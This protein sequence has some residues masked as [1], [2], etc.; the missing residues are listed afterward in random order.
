MLMPMTVALLAITPLSPSMSD[1]RMILDQI[2]PSARVHV[3]EAGRIDRIYGTPMHS[4]A[5]PATAADAFVRD[6]AAIWAVR[7]DQLHPVGHPQL[8]GYQPETGNYKFTLLTYQ[9][10]VGDV[11]VYESTLRVLVRNLQRPTVVLASADLHPTGGWSTSRSLSSAEAVVLSLNAAAEQLGPDVRLVDTPQVVV[12]AGAGDVAHEPRLVV[13]ATAAVGTNGDAHYAKRR[14]VV[15]AITGEVLHEENRIVQCMAA[16]AAATAMGDVTGTVSARV[17]D[18]WSAWECD[19]TITEP[20]P[21][22]YVDVGGNIVTTDANGQFSADVSGDVTV[23]AELRGPWFN[24]NNI[25]GSDDLVSADAS[26]GDDV[27]LLF[28]KDETELIMAQAV[29][30]RDANLVRDFILSVNPT[31][32][33]I[34][35]QTDW[36]INVNLSDTCNAYYD[37]SSINFFQTGGGCNNTAFGHVVF[38]EYGHHLIAEA[39]SGQGEYG[40]GM[41]DCISLLMTGDPVMA[42]GFFIGNCVSGI[43]DADNSCQYSETGCSSCGSAIH[44]CGQLISGCVYDTW[45][46]LQSKSPLEAHAIISSLTIDSILLHTGTGINDA[47]AIDF[48]TLDDDDGNLENGSPNYNEIAQGFNMHDL[49]V[50]PIAWL[51]ITLPEGPPS[52]IQPDGM[53]SMPV[54]IDSL[55]GNY[56]S[57]TARLFAGQDGTTTPVDLED[58]GSGDFLA[59][60]P[61]AECGE[62]VDWFIWAKTVDNDNTFL[63]ATAPD[64]RIS[65][66]AAWS[67]PTIAFADDGATDPG[68]TVSGDATDGFWER[69]IP[70]GGNNRPNEDCGTGSPNCWITEN[71]AGGGGDVDGGSTILTSPMIDATGVDEV[72]YCWWYRNIG[73]GNNVEDDTWVVNVSDDNGAT[74]TLLQQ[75]DVTGP[76]VEGNW[77]TSTFDLTELS[78]FELNEQFRIQFVASD[79]NETSRVEA[80]VDNVRMVQIDCS[81]QPCPSDID[82][83]GDVGTNDILALL[84]AWGDCGSCPEDVTGDGIVGV[85]D[86][87]MLVGSFGPCP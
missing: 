24:T 13:D 62:N 36:P 15:D 49:N 78:G 26:D 85:D 87:L 68:W 40:E 3:T 56:Q 67:E 43:R 21:W 59:H 74:W 32:P 61:T 27:E 4:A 42:P 1:T 79:L 63:P 72:S 45:M 77:Q 65:S 81:D 25:A 84:S 19:P 60:F 82:G 38:H 37:Y 41:S 44:A 80:A 18:G 6:T 57:G 9:Q 54:R 5:T 2:S 64:D 10:S 16:V 28:N 12:F 7:P 17:N 51:S 34:G 46:A 29:A 30:Y 86:L 52:H 47:I 11:P 14:F 76:D 66:I 35:T 23:L 83:D 73:G 53:T 31:Y 48:V 75:T 20:L 69:G 50:P 22:T 8:L 33:T 71:T 58:L 55:L 70:A 39:G